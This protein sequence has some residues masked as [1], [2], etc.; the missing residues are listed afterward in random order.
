M[1]KQL[2]QTCPYL[3]WQPR[4][5]NIKFYGSIVECGLTGK[6]RFRVSLASEGCEPHKIPNFNSKRVQW[7]LKKNIETLFP[8]LNPERNWEK[9]F[10]PSPRLVPQ[11]LTTETIYPD[12]H[13]GRNLL[14]FSEIKKDRDTLA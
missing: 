11:D 3:N 12:Y 13:C 1:V 2:C 4:V 6:K 10:G 5:F 14:L 9:E 7:F 8:F